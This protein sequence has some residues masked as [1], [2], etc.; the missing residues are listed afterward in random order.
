MSKELLREIKEEVMQSK[1]D[2][3]VDETIQIISLDKIEK[4][5]DY[6]EKQAERVQ[7]LEKEN[8][9]IKEAYNDRI[10]D[11]NSYQNMMGIGF[12]DMAIE[13]PIERIQGDKIN[14]L[15]RQNT[16]YREA[17]KKIARIN[18]EQGTVTVSEVHAVLTAREALEGEE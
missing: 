9:R 8:K 5:I 3:L 18:I 15:E 13:L 4:L 7:K 14:M 10:S 1:V 12:E 17:L 2:F 11:I 16:R 6:A